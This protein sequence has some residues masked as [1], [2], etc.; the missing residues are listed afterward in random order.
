[1]RA[2]YSCGVYVTLAFMVGLIPARAAQGQEPSKSAAV[3]HD[4][5]IRTGDVL[6]LRVWP[7]RR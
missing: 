1:M 5:I 2:R 4:H 3:V 7:S 6:R